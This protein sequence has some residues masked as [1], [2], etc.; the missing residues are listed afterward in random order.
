[1][2]AATASTRFSASSTSATRPGVPPTALSSPVRLVC[3]VI[4]PPASTAT[5]AM[6]EQAREQGAGRQYLLLVLDEQAVGGGDLLPRD[7]LRRDRGRIV[8]HRV[9][10]RERP[11]RRG[12]LELQV[13]QVGGRLA[14]AERPDERRGVSLGDPGH[15]GA[16]VDLL[17]VQREAALAADVAQVRV[18]RL[19][20]GHG[21]ARHGKRASVHR[22]PVADADAERVG[23]CALEHDPARP[24][25]AAGR[26]PRLVYRRRL[27]RPDPRRTPAP[28]GHGRGSPRPRPGTVRCAR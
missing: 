5:L 18:R 25:P 4:R 9:P 22:D 14:A 23:E 20:R 3:S 27:L 1:M 19:G 10:G 13:Q 16:A 24:H 15:A 6:C 17:R 26:R 11:R 28:S 7:D 8:V 2:A 12:V 21:D